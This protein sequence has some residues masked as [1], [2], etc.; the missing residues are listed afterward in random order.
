MSAGVRTLYHAIFAVKST[1]TISTGNIAA[2][3]G[4]NLTSPVLTVNVEHDVNGGLAAFVSMNIDGRLPILIHGVAELNNII[5]WLRRIS[6]NSFSISVKLRYR[7]MDHIVHY[8]RYL[9]MIECLF[10]T[11]IGL[12]PHEV[13]SDKAH[14]LILQRDEIL[15][16]I[17]R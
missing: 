11:C 13:M 6:Y 8:R 15:C 12:T 16:T 7:H 3:T 2:K 9:Y 1:G 10:S 17:L 14:G 5:T 4:F